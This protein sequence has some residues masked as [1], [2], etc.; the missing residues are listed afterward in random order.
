MMVD[1]S[2][3]S[4]IQD[5]SFTIHTARKIKARRIRYPNIVAPI[6]NPTEIRAAPAINAAARAKFT[7]TMA[8]PYALE[9]APLTPQMTPQIAMMIGATMSPRLIMSFDTATSGAGPSNRV[10]NASPAVALIRQPPDRQPLLAQQ[11]FVPQV[12]D[13]ARQVRP[14]ALRSGT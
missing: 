9:K 2:A 8:T 14:C 5:A 13:A 12:R 11:H 1:P 10:V 6:I 3:G 4:E 7:N